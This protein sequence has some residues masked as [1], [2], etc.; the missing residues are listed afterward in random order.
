M[1]V[2]AVAYDPRVVTIWDGF[3]ELFA[4]QS[5]ALD[6]V[7]YSNYER[8]VEALLEGII[9]VAWNSPLA[10]VR[11]RRMSV[12]RELE[13]RPLV[14][15][16]TD[17]DL[18]SAIVVREDS[19]IERIEDLAGRRV[20]V[21][22]PDSPQ[23]TLL[24]LSYLRAEGLAPGS[25]REVRHDLM[26]GKHGDHGAAEREEA[27]AL[28]DGRIDAA[29]VLSG[30]HILFVSEGIVPA[31]SLRVLAETPPFDHCNFTVGPAAP[32]EPVARFGQLLLEMNYE[33]PTVRTLFELEG[34]R[35]WV[36]AR[37]GGYAALERAVDETGFYDR[38]GAITAR[39]YRF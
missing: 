13:V 21:G 10:W 17:R 24:P 37:T 36:Q 35:A 16:D 1:V 23:A 15:R 14:M 20:G 31:G 33:D 39:D 19:S 25:F 11:A 29:C 32:Q 12:A 5:L 4:R 3:K 9:D 27:R 34:L 7:L 26:G 30:N 38:A 6:F 22:A 18:A 2:G 8:Q 28:V